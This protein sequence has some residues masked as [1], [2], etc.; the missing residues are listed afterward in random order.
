M[1]VNHH[2]S[3]FTIDDAR[4]VAFDLYGLRATARILPGERDYNFHL[5]SEAGKVFVLKVAH[6]EEQRTILDLQNKALECLA[7]GDP[8]LCLP[9][10]CATSTGETIA[11]I[12][13]AGGKAHFVRL[14]TFVPGKLFAETRPHTPEL[15]HSLGSIMGRMDRVLQDF[16]HPAA[17]RSLKWD[18]QHAAWIR[19][20]LRYIVQPGRRAVVERF[21]SRFEEHVLPVLPALRM[22]VIHNDANDYNILVN[23]T[24]PG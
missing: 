5:E 13:A 18:L 3:I 17:H 21:L 4:R 23:N 9:Q 14:L 20:Y 24:Y 22:S 11:T 15:L 10:V 16:T 2:A 8:S 7:A 19:D 6:A 12:T 1:N